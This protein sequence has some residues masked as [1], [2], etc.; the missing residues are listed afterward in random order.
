MGT[1][2][3]SATT[4]AKCGGSGLTGEQVYERIS[5][6]GGIWLDVLCSCQSE[7]DGEA[8]LSGRRSTP[9]TGTIG[10]LADREQSADPASDAPNIRRAQQ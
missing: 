5:N 6:E 8:V 2:Q 9:P 7:Y 1:D 10:P 4:C 3:R